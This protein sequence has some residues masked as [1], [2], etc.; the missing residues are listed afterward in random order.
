MALPS[1][2]Q[3]ALREQALAHT[4]VGAGMNKRNREGEDNSSF[5]ALV[6]HIKEHYGKD[7]F[8]VY[9]AISSGMSYFKGR[10]LQ[11]GEYERAMQMAGKG[12]GVDRDEP[13]R[14]VVV[15]DVKIFEAL[16]EHLKEHYGKDTLEIFRG[17]GV[18][19][20]QGED[21]P[22]HEWKRAM[23]MAGRGNELDGDYDTWKPVIRIKDYG[24]AL[25]R[26]RGVAAKCSVTLTWKKS[27]G[28]RTSLTEAVAEVLKEWILGGMR[29]GGY[30]FAGTDAPSVMSKDPNGPAA[31]NNVE[32]LVQADEAGTALA[33]SMLA[34]IVALID[35]S[36]SVTLA[37]D[38][39][40]R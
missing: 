5:E 37:P 7:T 6:E 19:Y 32:I 13:E 12:N 38:Y 29:D 36:E 23:Q 31:L 18:T 27:K 40:V 8:E 33:A 1:L 15:M 21:V 10:A 14:G 28:R 20:F 2:S 26:G 39:F 4:G 9:R 30:G 16:V 11:Q 35:P 22:E 34:K 3:L 25:V 17:N 24:P